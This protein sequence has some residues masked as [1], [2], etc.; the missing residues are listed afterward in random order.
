MPDLLSPY[1]PGVAATFTP[2][3]ER[4]VGMLERVIVG[5]AGQSTFEGRVQVLQGARGVGKTSVLRAVERT[6]RR[7]GLSTVFVTAGADGAMP[8]VGSGLHQCMRE[9][10]PSGLSDQFLAAISSIGVK[11]GPAEVSV[12][13][14][15]RDCAPE[16]AVAGLKRAVADV[17]RAAQGAN[18]GLIIFIDEFQDCPA[19]EI[20]ALATAWQEL[21]GEAAFPDAGPLPAAL[22]TAGMSNTQDR[23]TE[24]A[25]FAERFRF[26]SLGNLEDGAATQALLQ[27]AVELGVTW[28]E[29][30]V[31]LVLER[32]A[33]YPYFLQL[34]AHEIWDAAP[35]RPG[36]RLGEADAAE[37]IAA[38]AGQIELFYR[39][40]WNRATEA[41]QRLLVAIAESGKDE[42]SRTE[43]A[44]ALGVATGDLSMPRASLLGKGLL[45]VPRRGM[46]ALNAPGF[47]QFILDERDG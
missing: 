16:P 5:V 34:Y 17:A 35:R 32:A 2:G 8:A 1:T 18:R 12:G 44:E 38:A 30:A 3:R 10:S 13:I 41:E 31:A 26:E 9:L 37:G 33:G 36:D 20:R 4:Q 6:A 7:L 15:D 28:D 47:A 21:Q 22:V 46:L 25:S 27:P 23:I 40:R 42:V 14:R 43:I 11:L 24:A 29:G 19:T 45:A 39:G